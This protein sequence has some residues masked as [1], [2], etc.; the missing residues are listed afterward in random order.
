MCLQL[1]FQTL[2]FSDFNS[3]NS[4]CNL[5]DSLIATIQGLGCLNHLQSLKRISSLVFSE[6]SFLT[7]SVGVRDRFSPPAWEC[8]GIGIET[9]AL[10]SSCFGTTSSWLGLLLTVIY[11]NILLS[12][13]PMGRSYDPRG[14][15]SGWLSNANNFW[16]KYII[17]WNCCE[18]ETSNDI[19]PINNRSVFGRVFFD[20]CVGELNESPA[21]K[22]DSGAAPRVLRTSCRFPENWVFNFLVLF[23]IRGFKMWVLRIFLVLVFVKGKSICLYC[24][25]VCVEF[26][27]LFSKVFWFWNFLRIRIKVRRMVGLSRC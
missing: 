10:I 11:D 9:V 26:R 22:A 1:T 2:Q 23:L 13:W 5:L 24:L 12:C 25:L 14:D 16:M 6:K 20:G 8:T 4:F 18:G 17:K 19:K 21:A 7:L 15:V 3:L 27:N